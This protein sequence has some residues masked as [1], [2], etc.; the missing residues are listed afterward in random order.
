MGK[1]KAVFNFLKLMRITQKYEKKGRQIDAARAAGDDVLQKKLIPEVTT[2]WAEET[3]KAF[4]V[5]LRI[6]GQENVPQQD[7]IV[8][9][10]NHQG[11]VD[12]PV[13][14]LVMRNRPLGFISKE[15]VQ[16]IPWIGKWVNRSHAL[17][18]RRDNPKEAL[19][20]IAGGAKEIQ[21]GY[22]IGIYPEGT[23]SQGP[24]IGPFKPG[25]FKL[26]TKA[27][28]PILP[29]TLHGTYHAFE[30]KGC[31]QPCVVRVVI[32]PVVETKDLDRH[33]IVEMEKQVE[34][35]IRETFDRLVAEEA[36]EMQAKA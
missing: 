34:A 2:P 32:H 26:A 16:K 22:N 8:L 24:F 23:R 31:A 5:E 21:K 15:E 27:K 6:E 10:S 18:I 25:A 14:I 12:I 11:Y 19:K 29:V 17:F 30:E 9:I 28:A 1:I 35:T 3:L 13:D 4:G 20:S 7:G 33:G 36:A